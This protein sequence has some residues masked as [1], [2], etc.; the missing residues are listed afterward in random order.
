ML[1]AG[2]G[3]LA[4][5]GH[6]GDFSFWQLEWIKLKYVSCWLVLCL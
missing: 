6:W 2:E 3:M 5:S 4:N 1:T